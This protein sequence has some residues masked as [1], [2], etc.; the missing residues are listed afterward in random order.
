MDLFHVLGFPTWEK[1][2]FTLFANS[3]TELQSIFQHYAKSG[4]AGAARPRRR[5]RCRR[6]S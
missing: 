1:E 2:A 3:F 6:P 5:S 4:A